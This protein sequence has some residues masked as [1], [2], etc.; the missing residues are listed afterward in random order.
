MFCSNC[1]SRIPDGSNFCRK[2][3]K[4]Q[5]L[6]NSGNTQD[7]SRVDQ[8]VYNQSVNRGSNHYHSASFSEA[9][10]RYQQSKGGNRNDWYSENQQSRSYHGNGQSQYNGQSRYSG[11]GHNTDI[12]T[13]TSARMVVGI[14]IAVLVILVLILL[15]VTY[16]SYYENKKQNEMIEE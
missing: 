16:P 13:G 6:G 15:A 10:D 9:E 7:Q 5:N 3:G 1:G 4:K 14:I 11:Q 2:C 8:T 12:N